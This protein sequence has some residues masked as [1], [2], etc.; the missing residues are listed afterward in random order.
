M[1]INTWEAL[2]EYPKLKEEVEQLRRWKREAMVVLGHWDKVIDKVPSRHMTLGKDN[3]ELVGL[4]IDALKAEL[5]KH[6]WG[7]F[8]YGDQSQDPNIT[9]LLD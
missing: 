4:Y 7:D 8:H 5:A 6:G 2:E 1:M 3:A 9:A